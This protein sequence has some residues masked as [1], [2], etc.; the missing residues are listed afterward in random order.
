MEEGF[1]VTAITRMFLTKYRLQAVSRTQSFFGARVIATFSIHCHRRSERPKEGQEKEKQIVGRSQGEPKRLRKETGA[2]LRVHHAPFWNYLIKKSCMLPYFLQ[3]GKYLSEPGKKN[4]VG[5]AQICK[6]KLKEN[7][8][9]SQ[10]II[11][12]DHCI[13]SFFGA[14]NRQNSRIWSFQRP[15]TVYESPQSSPILAIW[16]TIFRTEN[17]MFS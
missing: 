4:I 7:F 8:N 17:V 12:C 1:G 10:R 13:F 2:A 5:F 6:E 14:K 15:E 11:L 9:F 16:C 3:I